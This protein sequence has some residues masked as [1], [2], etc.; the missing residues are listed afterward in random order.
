MSGIMTISCGVSIGVQPHDDIRCILDLIHHILDNART[1]I[2]IGT[3]C[4]PRSTEFINKLRE[5]SMKV[6]ALVLVYGKEEHISYVHYLSRI[7]AFKPLIYI[8]Y[9]HARYIVCDH[10]VYISSAT[11]HTRASYIT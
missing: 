1:F 3:Y 4:L 7:I 9:H 6:E 10:G 11:S 8:P 2:V 5:V